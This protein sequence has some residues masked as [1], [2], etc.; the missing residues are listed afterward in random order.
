MSNDAADAAWHAIKTSLDRGWHV[1][2]MHGVRADGSCTCPKGAACTDAGKHPLYRRGDDGEWHQIPPTNDGKTL[3]S[4]LATNPTANVGL[5][6][7]QSG[8]L[9]I[10][11][12]TDEGM[13]ECSSAGHG[14]PPT[15]IRH[16]RGTAYIYRRP[17]GCPIYRETRAG[18]S[19]GFDVLT[20]GWLVI[21][22]KHRDGHEVYTTGDDLD[23]A[24][25]W[26]VRIITDAAPTG[27]R[28]TG[29]AD[30]VDV[31][32]ERP[33]AER[34]L[35]LIAGWRADDYGEWVRVGMALS[36]LGDAGLGLWDAW[37]KQ[38]GKHK[39]GQCARKWKTFTPD[40]G[41]TLGTLY[42]LA[43][44][45]SGTNPARG[46]R[47][48][49][50]SA[51]KKRHVEPC[52]LRAVIEAHQRWL[53]MPDP[54]ALLFM[55]GVVQANRLRGDPVWGMA[56]GAPGYGK[57]E[58]LNGL[59]HVEHV[60]SAS[61]ITEGALLSGVA[62]RDRT[63]D[64]NGG[65][66]RT[67]GEYGLLI[68]KDFTSIISMHREQRAAILAALR[69]C[70]D[71]SWTRHVGVD[72]GRTLTWCGKLGILAGCTDA[73]DSAHAV[74]GS[75]GE[76]FVFYRIDAGAD[77]ER[78]K[79][80][81]AHS[82]REAEMR[83][84]LADVIAGLFAGIQDRAPDPLSKEQEKWLIEISKLA[85]RCRSHVERDPIRREITLVPGAEAPT[86]LVMVL[87]KLCQ[88][89][90]MIGVSDEGTKA[91]V[92]RVALDS[93]PKVR[94]QVLRTLAAITTRG[95]GDVARKM[96]YPTDTVRHA[97]QDLEA[98]GVLERTA[99][100]DGKADLW[101]F[102]DWAKKGY[103][104]AT[105]TYE[106]SGT[107][108]MCWWREDGASLN[109]HIPITRQNVNTTPPGDRVCPRCGEDRLGGGFGPDRV[110]YVCYTEGAEQVPTEEP[111]DERQD[112]PAPPPE[113]RGGS[114]PEREGAP[115][116]FPLGVRQMAIDRAD[117]Q[118]RMDTDHCTMAE[119][120]QALKNEITAAEIAAIR[121]APASEAATR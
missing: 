62:K 84:E 70:Y 80:A 77:E 120:V 21:H 9:V 88:A 113:P 42:W 117:I 54:G 46:G 23:D 57:T 34:A 63:K 106:T 97:L 20:G 13:E 72:G 58:L 11:V 107:G 39:D 104:A 92:S 71:G 110:C 73:I 89:L 1:G 2:L 3:H 119:A 18:R 96:G 47:V 87:G 79:L 61:T 17:A 112:E 91:I 28:T 30:P 115:V 101:S 52:G 22:G 26:A 7:E 35:S 69:E 6:I 44:Q 5:G 121:A 8:V 15:I 16:S 37:S 59:A 56:V 43:E 40:K 98:H 94:R 19:G 65:L 67:I 103:D 75:L 36:Q 31:D 29:N 82:G 95:T 114:E 100:G 50:S 4:L 64:S 10:D 53:H 55:L 81:L 49:S 118:A 109:T 48:F 83:A 66:L 74:M 12:D 85:V 108:G 86:R 116:R 41:T 45:D 60:H 93:M 102:T 76:R 33:I 105:T 78:A 27:T 99:Q 25:A 90:A 32:V 51:E 38:S 24:P 14:L 68:L 111:A